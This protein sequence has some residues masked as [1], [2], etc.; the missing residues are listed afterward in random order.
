MSIL[1]SNNLS[2]KKEKDILHIIKEIE[3]IYIMR[4][5]ATWIQKRM[6]IHII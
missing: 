6:C 5:V 1:F 2:F 3:S 4:S